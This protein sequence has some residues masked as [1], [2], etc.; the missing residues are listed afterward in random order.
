MTAF[1][2]SDHHTTDGFGARRRDH[3]YWFSVKT[4]APAKAKRR[5]D[6]EEHSDFNVFSWRLCAFAGD[7]NQ[8]A[9]LLDHCRLPIGNKTAQ[10]PGNCGA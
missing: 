3:W 8:T 1:T 4:F 10:A 9:P 7:C 5:K 6:I 2:D